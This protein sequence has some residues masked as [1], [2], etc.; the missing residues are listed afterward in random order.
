MRD[1]TIFED[2]KVALQLWLLWPSR[3]GFLYRWR[4]NIENIDILTIIAFSIESAMFF[5]GFLLSVAKVASW[6]PFWAPTEV[7]FSFLRE[8]RR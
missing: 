6:G 5:P 3:I 1:K 2:F 7:G 8:M 4:E